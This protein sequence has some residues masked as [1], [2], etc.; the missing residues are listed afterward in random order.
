MQ[1]SALLVDGYTD[2]PPGKLATVVTCLEATRPPPRRPARPLDRALVVEH[3]QRPDPAAYRALFR[4]VGEDWLW[5]SRLVLADEALAA[6]LGDADV[7]VHVLKDRRRAIGLVELD[8]R[9]EGQ[10]EIAFLGVV[11][12]EIGRGL[13][14]HL[15]GHAL[16]RAW[17]RPIRRVWLHSCTFDHPGAVAF[18]RRSG[19]SPYAVMVE[20][21]DDPRVTGHLPASAAPHVPLIP[22]GARSEG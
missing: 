3:W 1:A 16:T 21:A 7:E 22:V 11:G 9:Q 10:C 15:M 2:V 17:A 19:F 20:V 6:I 8:F 14:R 4:L 12:E 13:G 18:Y 5:F